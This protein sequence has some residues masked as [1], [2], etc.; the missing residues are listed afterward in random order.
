MNIVISLIITTLLSLGIAFGLS[1]FLSI[2]YGFVLCFTLIIS[3]SYMWKGYKIKYGD[4]IV[5][6][7]IEYVE[8]ITNRNLCEIECPCSK[9]KTIEPV[10]ISE[11]L[12]I[13]CPKCKNVF[14]VT[15]S[16]QI[17]LSTDPKVSDVAYEAL[18][19]KNEEVNELFKKIQ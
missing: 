6:E 12:T 11:V 13:N 2:I 7:L 8:D 16:T 3:I 18:T 19:V 15:P 14:T 10:F 4:E 5:S 1:P 17:A 9:Y